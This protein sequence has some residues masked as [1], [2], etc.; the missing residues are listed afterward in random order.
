M[1]GVREGCGKGLCEG[2]VKA[3]RGQCEGSEKG[4]VER[5]LR[6]FC[7]GSEKGLRGL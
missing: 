5:V 7:E 1:G 4:S 6:R 3:V 2:S